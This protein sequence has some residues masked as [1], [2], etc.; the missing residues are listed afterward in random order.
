MLSSTVFITHIYR[1]MKQFTGT[2]EAVTLSQFMSKHDSPNLA[3]KICILKNADFP[4]DVPSKK[5]H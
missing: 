1:R 4:P 5:I 3:T 2:T